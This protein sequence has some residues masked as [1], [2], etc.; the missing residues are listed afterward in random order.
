[1]ALGV[2]RVTAPPASHPWLPTGV[3]RVRV[4]GALGLLTAPRGQ[5][6]P[7]TRSRHAGPDAGPPH[8]HRGAGPPRAL[9]APRTAPAGRGGLPP[10]TAGGASPGPRGGPAT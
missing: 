10:P 1:M 6:A 4:P 7:G 3:V 8:V 9:A 2:S 5:R